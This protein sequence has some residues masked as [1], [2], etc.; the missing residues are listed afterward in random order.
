FFHSFTSFFILALFSYICKSEMHPKLSVPLQVMTN[1]F[2]SKT[3][4]LGHTLAKEVQALMN[5]LSDAK[6]SNFDMTYS[7]LLLI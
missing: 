6:I 4:P 5:C 3:S 2:A 1:S 7:S